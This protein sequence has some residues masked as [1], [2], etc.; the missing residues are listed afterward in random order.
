MPATISIGDHPLTLAEYLAVTE[1]GS[2]AELSAEGRAR[3]EHFRAALI[4]LLDSGARIYGVNTGYGADSTTSLPPEVIAEVQRNTLTSHSVG[5][6]LTLPPALTRGM[7]LLKANVLAQGYSAVRPAVAE[8]CLDLINHDILPIIPEQGSLAASGDLIPQGHLG[9][10]LIGE[11]DVLWRGEIATAE[12]ALAVAGIEPLAPEAKEGL[13]LVNGTAFTTAYALDNVVRVERL[14]QTADICAAASLQAL[15][16]WPSAYDERL[17]ATRPFPGAL[18]TARNMRALIAESPL[19]ATPPDRVHDPYCLRCVPQVHGAVRGAYAYARDAAL[20]ELNAETDNPLV[21]PDSGACISGGNFHSEPVGIPMDTLAVAVAELG[22]ISQR[23]TQHLVS[24][25]Y[26]VGLPPKLSPQPQLGSGLFMMNTSASAL[27]SENKAL[28]FPA[29]VDNQAVDAVEDHTS[30]ASVA[31][32][33]ASQI[34]RNTANILAV[35][36]IC[37][38]QGIDLQRPAAASA[39]IEAVHALVRERVPFITEDRGLYHEIRWTAEQI[40]SGA[41]VR[42]AEEVMGQSLPA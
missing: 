10:A 35:E 7:L 33:K 8:R 11:G 24:P 32:R 17:V 26:D 25:V 31:A 37:A 19:L 5:T 20:I 2:R 42:R 34:I 40:L 9:Q 22:S 21:F 12:E 3:M 4:D 16:G 14:L 30:M 6:G 15:R 38:C 27:V 23:R 36:L 39:P 18:Q 28:S 41:I 1:E 13:A 29:S